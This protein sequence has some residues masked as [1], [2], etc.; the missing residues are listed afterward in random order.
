MTKASQ[1]KKPAKKLKCFYATRPW[2]CR[3]HKD[4]SE[5]VAYVEASGNWEAVA[6]F[7]TTSG[8]S[9]EDMALFIC[10]LINDDQNNKPLLRDAMEALEL[11]LED[12]GLT[13]SSEQA[14]D[15]VV[16]RIKARVS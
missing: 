8:V 15:K 16:T 13:F 14:A 5:I 6:D 9:A 1:P 2:E 3:H 7:R 10:G 4:H 12:D 11:C